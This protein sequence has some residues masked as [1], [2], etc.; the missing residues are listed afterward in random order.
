[1]LSEPTRRALE[2]AFAILMLFVVAIVIVASSGCAGETHA[3]PTFKV[4]QSFKVDATV[5]APPLA[6]VTT[7]H[8]AP[9]AVIAD[10]IFPPKAAVKL[11][12]NT[13]RAC[14]CGD[15]CRCTNCPDDCNTLA[16]G[17]C[18]GGVCLMPQRSV[19]TRSTA[20]HAQAASGDCGSGACGVRGKVRAAGSKAWNGLKG[21]G[22]FIVRRFRR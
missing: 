20:N 19:L 11:D 15:V 6:E 21:A 22:K 14:T 17:D 13:Y 7:S 3:A 10:T 2:F 1:M 12:A 8:V 5:T 18:P 9:P 4:D 16:R